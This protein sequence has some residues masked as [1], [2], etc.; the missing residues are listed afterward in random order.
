M[1]LMPQPTLHFSCTACGGCCNR[2]PEVELSETLGLA[3]AFIFRLMLRPYDIPATPAD[4]GRKVGGKATLAQRRRYLEERKLLADHAVKIFPLPSEGGRG[5]MTRYIYISAIAMDAG[6]GRCDHL[7]DDGTC[8][9]YER[10]PHACRTVPFHYSRADSGLGSD[11]TDFLTQPAHTCASGTDAEIA[12]IGGALVLPEYAAARAAARRTM[13]ADKPWKEAIAA[14]IDAATDD[15]PLWPTWDAINANAVAGASTVPMLQAW[16]IAEQQG[17]ITLHQLRDYLNAQIQLLSEAFVDQ[18]AN[19]TFHTML[20][21][22]RAATNNRH[23]SDLGAMG[24]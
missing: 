9:L 14:R 4:L 22:Y 20:T 16:E 10:R 15:D 7:A 23:K 3:D 13:T 12:M 19:T 18:N 24:V 6:A 17:R 11:L 21:Q 1:R 8:N 2:N 5:K